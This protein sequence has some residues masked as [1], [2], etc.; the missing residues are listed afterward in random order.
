MS[1]G[2]LFLIAA[3]TLS[4]LSACT[5]ENALDRN[6][7]TDVFSQE[8]TA[9]VDILWVVDNSSSMDNEQQLVA[10]GFEAFISTIEDT[11]I[12]F[13]IGVITTDMDSTNTDRGVLVG[14]PPYLTPDDDYITLFEDRVRLGVDGSDQEKGLAA[15]LEALT[16]PKASGANAGFL[17]EE[18]VLSIIFVADED[19]CSDS[20]RMAG[21]GGDA[22]YNNEDLLDPVK[23]YIDAY[24]AIK[25][26]VETRV[27][28]SGIIGPDVEE[29]CPE[30]WPGHRY[31]SVSEGL[32]GI[33]GSI[34]ESDYS[35]IMDQ[36]G[37]AASGVLTVFQLSNVPVVETLEVGVDDQLIPEDPET[38]WN[39]DD[40]YYTIRFDGSY[41]P[42]RG[43]TVTITYEIAGAI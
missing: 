24:K 11:N 6:K 33:V 2:S 7:F 25:T 5:P 38:G 8:P 21:M 29:D 34:C 22:C 4:T 26:G 13:H 15:A 36:M 12:N 9:D 42:P 10:D 40:V 14:D 41:V 32:S 31:R 23:D 28:A 3:V 18:A 19:D 17:R 35:N 30:S 43:S 39:Y 27:I 1:R 37:L 20:D 16:E